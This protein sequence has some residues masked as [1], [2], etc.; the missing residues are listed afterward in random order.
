MRKKKYRKRI[1]KKKGVATLK[2][3]GDFGQFLN[4]VD[5]KRK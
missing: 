5:M 2:Y 4:K 1:K 3:T